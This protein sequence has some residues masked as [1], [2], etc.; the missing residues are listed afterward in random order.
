MKQ[1]CENQPEILIYG[2]SA[3]EDDP[4]FDAVVF[5]EHGIFVRGLGETVFG[6]KVCQR[7]QHRTDHFAEIIRA[8]RS[9]VLFLPTGFLR[10][11]LPVER[12]EAFSVIFCQFLNVYSLYLY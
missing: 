1:R 12:V 6:H 7:I 9:F 2:E 5:P 3:Y 8:F 4:C 11:V 10:G